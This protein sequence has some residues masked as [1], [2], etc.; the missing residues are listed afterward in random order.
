MH[1]GLLG[2]EVWVA[3]HSGE[4]VTLGV[5]L[6]HPVRSADRCSDG[7]LLVAGLRIATHGSAHVALGV[8]FVSLGGADSG[9]FLS[10][11]LVRAHWVSFSRT[12]RRFLCWRHPVTSP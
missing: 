5:V 11:C 12:G 7:W 2:A 3:A 4:L 8:L 10:V 9:G 1:G 6:F